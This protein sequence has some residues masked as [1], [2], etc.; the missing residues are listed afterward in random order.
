MKKVKEL[1]ING[2]SIIVTKTNTEIREGVSTSSKVLK[3]ASLGEIYSYYYV[4]LKKDGNS[5]YK[6]KLDDSYGYI[7]GSNISKNFIVVDKSLQKLILYKSEQVIL[8]TEVVTGMYTNHDTPTGF[9]Q[10][11]V[12]NLK[13]AKTL[14]GYN[15]DGSK[16]ASYVDYWMPFIT[17]RGIGFHDAT[18]RSNSEFTDTRYLYDGSHGCVN[19]KKEAAK[20]LFNNI[21]KDIDVI[22]RD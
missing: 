14:R 20:T 2:K 1:E 21:D 12:K 17:N 8:N 9:Y 16:Y 13:K 4:V 7:K 6:V 3:K 19:M 10:L 15:D 22:I 5:W 18:W 11:K